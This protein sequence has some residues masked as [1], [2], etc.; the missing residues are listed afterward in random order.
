MKSCPLVTTLMDLKGIMLSEINQYLNILCPIKYKK[1]NSLML[2]K[3][4][5]DLENK[6]PYTAHNVL[7]FCNRPWED[8]KSMAQGLIDRWNETVTN[9]DIVYFIGTNVKKS[10]LKQLSRYCT[11]EEIKINKKSHYKIIEINDVVGEIKDKRMNNGSKNVK[12][13]EHLETALALTILKEKDV[14]MQSHKDSV[15]KNITC[16]EIKNVIEVL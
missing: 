11:F 4:F 10:L 7:K 15:L 6:K 14:L 1:L 13:T 2:Q 12:F 8:E 9:D 16:P 3:F 5:D